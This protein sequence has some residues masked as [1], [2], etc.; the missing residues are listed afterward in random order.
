MDGWLNGREDVAPTIDGYGSARGDE[1]QE[2]F[3]NGVLLSEARTTQAW[4]SG[5]LK[6]SV[7]DL[8]NSSRP[9]KA[10]SPQLR[11]ELGW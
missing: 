10:T 7:D 1:Y 4:R 9:R 11:P 5:L 3:M 8:L 6:H 2:Q